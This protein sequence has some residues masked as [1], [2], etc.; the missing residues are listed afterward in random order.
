[1]QSGEDRGKFADDEF[2]AADDSLSKVADECPESVT[3]HADKQ[4][5]GDDSQPEADSERTL[6]FATDVTDCSMQGKA[7]ANQEQSAEPKCPGYTGSLKTRHGSRPMSQ[8]RS[9]AAGNR[10]CH[11]RYSKEPQRQ[12][13]GPDRTKF[14]HSAS[15]AAPRLAVN[16]L[17]LERSIAQQVFA[18]SGRPWSW[19]CPF[20]EETAQPKSF[21][22]D[23]TC[24]ARSPC[25][26]AGSSA[27]LETR[28]TRR[29]R[30]SPCGSRNLIRAP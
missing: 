9:Q 11:D 30:C 15:L 1:M 5:S 23:R 18:L 17:N 8:Q 7:S 22:S 14:C 3:L 16:R 29:P 24:L 21:Q 28:Q 27:C 20:L 6:L 10:E 19:Q 26:L 2:V 25:P 12:Q 4:R 13:A